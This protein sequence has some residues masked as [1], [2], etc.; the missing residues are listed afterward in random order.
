MPPTY[1]NYEHLRA[2]PDLK[3]VYFEKLMKPKPN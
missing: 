3:K 1:Y 2:N